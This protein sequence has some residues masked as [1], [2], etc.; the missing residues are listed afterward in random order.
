MD[1]PRL[2][3]VAFRNDLQSRVSDAVEWSKEYNYLSPQ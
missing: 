2:I 1:P 3:L